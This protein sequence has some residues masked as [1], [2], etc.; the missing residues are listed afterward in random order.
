MSRLT[1]ILADADEGY[2]ENVYHYM[3]SNYV[4]RFEVSL[5]T[6][7]TYLKASLTKNTKHI[8]ILLISSALYDEELLIANITCTIFLTAGKLATPIE[9]YPCINKYQHGGQLVA[10]M[11]NVFAQCNQE[12]V[13]VIAGNKATKIIGIYSPIGGVGKTSI[14][15]CASTILASRGGS[16]FY[17]NLENASQSTPYY[18]ECVNQH[19]FSNILFALKEK[20]K[21]LVLKMEG[22]RCID[23]HSNVHYFVPPDSITEINEMTSEEAKTLIQQ[24]KNMGQYD[25]ILI[26]MSS[27]FDM[28]CIDIMEQCDHI[29]MVVTPRGSDDI[30]VSSFN[31][32]LNIVLQ[33]REVDL[34]EKIV[35]VQN[36][37]SQGDLEGSD[38]SADFFLPTAKGVLTINQFIGT[39]HPFTESVAKMLKT[40]E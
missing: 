20:N 5:Y 17:L 4:D 34:K 40:L 30:R 29:M 13:A 39:N 35:L 12:G 19:T 2:A 9:G 7:I 14:A 16:A 15:V 32:E 11:L 23:T 27:A 26:D 10:D 31:K 24:F 21:N 3:M 8:D 1:V 36:K 28:R 37:S 6:D 33:T 18:F 25:Y 38:K 22:C